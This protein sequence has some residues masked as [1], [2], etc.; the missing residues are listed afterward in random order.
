LRNRGND[1]LVLLG[2]FN[3]H[4]IAED[5]RAAYADLHDSILSW[6]KANH[7][8]AIA[9]DPLPTELYADASH[10]LTQGYELLA[11]NL[12]ADP[13]FQAWLGK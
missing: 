9:P 7:V 10:P 6:L 3:E 1:V 8:T 2:P 5:N 4:M 12:Y 11:K 13:I